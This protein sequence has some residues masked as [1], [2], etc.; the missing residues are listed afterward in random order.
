MRVTISRETSLEVVR[1]V[2]AKSDAKR[3]QSNSPTIALEA[4]VAMA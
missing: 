3:R 2:E 1:L 4:Q